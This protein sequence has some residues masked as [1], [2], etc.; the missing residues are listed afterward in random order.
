MNDKEKEENRIQRLALHKIIC[1]CTKCVG[2]N[3]K[4]KL[5][6]NCKKCDDSIDILMKQK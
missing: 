2:S 5:C 3:I 6:S 4:S 1:Q